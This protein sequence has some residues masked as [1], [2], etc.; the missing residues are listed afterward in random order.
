MSTTH[1]LSE[2]ISST[3][4]VID[5]LSTLTTTERGGLVMRMVIWLSKAALGEDQE[6]LDNLEADVIGS[7]KDV[8]AVAPVVDGDQVLSSDD[9][10]MGG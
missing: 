9:V 8:D 2:W 7:A 6:Y 3:K 10:E 5:V 4:A 1:A